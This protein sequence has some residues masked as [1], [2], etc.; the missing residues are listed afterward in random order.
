[1]RRDNLAA[2][3]DTTDV[4]LLKTTLD[5]FEQAELIRKAEEK[6][7]QNPTAIV[8]IEQRR[9]ADTTLTNNDALFLKRFYAGKIYYFPETRVTEFPDSVIQQTDKYKTWSNKNYTVFSRQE[10][11][12]P[13]LF[14]QFNYLHTGRLY[15]DELFYKAINAYGQV[16]SWKQVDTRTIIRGDSVDVYYFLYPDRKQ[17]I[18][19]NL[20]ASRNTGDYLSLSDLFGLAL[21]ITYR[22]R[23]VWHRA[24]Q[25]STSFTNA[26]ELFNQSSDFLQAFQ[27]SLGQTYTIPRPFLPFK[28][29]KPGKLDFGRTV[30]NAN[31]SYAERKDF[32]RLRSLVANYG[33]D[34]KF[35]NN[36]WQVRIPNVELYSLDTLPSLAEAFEKNPFLRN[37]FNTGSVIG[38]QVSWTKTYA[39]SRNVTNYRRISGEI[40]GLPGLKSHDSKIY[41]FVKAEAEFRK[42]IAFRKTTL[43]LRALGGIGYNYTE[44]GP[45]GQTLPFFKQFV[46][47]GPNSMRAWA[48]RQLGLGS[49]ILSDT[50]TTFRDRYGDMQLEANAEYRYP[51]AHY[52]SVNIN[53]AFF[54]DAG[55]IWNVRKDTNNLNSE[56]QL[57]RLGED[58]AIGI[59]TGFRFDFNYF[60]IRV[61]MGIKFKDPARFEHNGVDFIQNFTW[62][63]K[64]F[65]TYDG[66]GNPVGAVRNN[67]AIQLGIGLP[68]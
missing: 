2:V 1:M 24:V 4:S 54:I 66:D 53:G 50:S 34:W 33:W 48:L 56:F 12:N 14:K 45:S 13:K 27:I 57:S 47:G 35:K 23:N 36:I 7:Q 55:N 26:V 52:S 60:L 42:L 59:G 8:T 64:E 58:I 68:F 30:I 32:F 37:S 29:K 43:A 19:Y 20:E 61:D 18:T 11:F 31:I 51:I 63:N 41:Q 49:S 38:G 6:R 17:N 9:L 22:N 67:Y 15:N 21:N 44:K 28:I 5:P 46:A 39:G 65:I 3:V 25:S 62:R 40:S 10:L 16:G